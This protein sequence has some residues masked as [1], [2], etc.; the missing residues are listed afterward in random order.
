MAAVN[1]ITFMPQEF[2]INYDMI[3]HLKSATYNVDELRAA[4]VEKI[5]ECMSSD[6]PIAWSP[7]DEVDD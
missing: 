2:A 7:S 1:T 6:V 3:P 4:V 5:G